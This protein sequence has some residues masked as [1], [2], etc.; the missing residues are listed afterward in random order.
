MSSSFLNKI[1]VLAAGLMLACGQPLAQVNATALDAEASVAQN[2][3]KIQ[4]TDRAG[5]HRFK[6]GLL[7]APQGSTV[8][9]AIQP[10][11]DGILMG[12]EGDRDSYE[13]LMYPLDNPEEVQKVLN[14]AADD[15]VMLM[16]G[17]VLKSSVEKVSELPYLPLPVIAI[18]RVS[19]EA[20]PELFMSIDM[21]MES[22]AAQL[23][24]IALENTASKM[25]DFVII[26]TPDPYDERV[27]R[28]IK[29]EIEKRGAV[30]EIRH[31]SEEQ[32]AYMNTEMKGKGF[33]GA[34][35]AMSPAKA[36]LIRPYLPEDLAV[37]GTSY[38]NPAGTQDSMAGKTQANDLMG[39]VTLEI[40]AITQMD[41]ADYA[42][43]RPYLIKLDNAD[44]HLFAVG[45][46]VWNLSKDWLRWNEHIELA[47]GLSGRITFDKSRS[48]RVERKMDKTVVTP[49][50]V[51]SADD[52]AFEETA[53]EAGL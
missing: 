39:M 34:F 3:A 29:E 9:K 16:I 41:A 50:A 22:E 14:R 18:N 31:I 49:N 24:D 52:V 48:S 38:T 30:A 17:P 23:V 7:T 51:N 11:K 21:T 47:G 27:A 2:D 12:Y 26:S 42:K 4:D 40:P 53:D 43:Y 44:R 10:L 28:A 19:N 20:V 15:G 6:V 33:R 32:L 45:V 25:G 13:L 1:S 5:S 35:F 36:S 8:E 46:D 37:F